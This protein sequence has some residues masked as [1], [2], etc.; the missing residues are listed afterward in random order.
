MN[1]KLD[2]ILE[3]YSKHKNQLI[4]AKNFSLSSKSRCNF[5]PMFDDIENEITFLLNLE[6]KPDKIVEFSPA[7][8]WSTITLCLAVKNNNKGKVFTYDIQDQCV[9]NLN[10][11]GLNNYFIFKKGDV[12]S[13]FHTFFDADYIFI[14]SDHSSN[15]A[16]NY[17]NNLIKPILS[18]QRK[19][20]FCIH[21]VFHTDRLNEEGNVVQNFL[22]NS[23]IP[24]FSPRYNFD[25]LTKHKE[26]LGINIQLHNST[27]NPSV[28]FN[29]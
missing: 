4:E 13:E 19:T 26:K 23:K 24:Y 29:F 6:N 21:D 15:F 11:I 9:H 2:Y 5:K 18:S 22:Q 14:D 7:Y 17:I 12:T 27:K 3:L 10:E 1:H 16:H 25:I 28:F 8:G 20:V